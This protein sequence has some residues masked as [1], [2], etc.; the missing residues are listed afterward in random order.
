[1]PDQLD[2]Q[3]LQDRKD[4]RDLLETMDP[5]AL[6]E[7]REFLETQVQRV[8]LEQQERMARLFYRGPEL[9]QVE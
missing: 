6:K 8:A 5:K 1:M 2:P 9:P 3:V 4:L 7:Y